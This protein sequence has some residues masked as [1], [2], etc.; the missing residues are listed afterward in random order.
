MDGQGGLCALMVCVA[1]VT[2][3]QFRWIALHTGWYAEEILGDFIGFNVFTQNRDP[4][5]TI[6]GDGS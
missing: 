6:Y 4:V 2:D 3:I 5:I 1:L